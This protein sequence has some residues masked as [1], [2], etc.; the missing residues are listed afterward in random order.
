VLEVPA[1][2]LEVPASAEAVAAWAA[3]EVAGSIPPW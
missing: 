2:V 3:G 1:A